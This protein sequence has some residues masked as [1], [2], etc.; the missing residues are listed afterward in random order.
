MLIFDFLAAA[1][2]VSRFFVCSFLGGSGSDCTQVVMGAFVGARTKKCE[3]L[4]K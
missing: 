2:F 1:E 4:D 3:G